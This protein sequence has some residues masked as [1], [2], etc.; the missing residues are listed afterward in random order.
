MLDTTTQR[1]TEQLPASQPA[2]RDFRQEVTNDIIRLL[3]QGVAPWQKPWQP[4]AVSLGMPMN[5]TTN[6]TY[7]GGNAVHLM[8]TGLRKGYA[9]PRWMTYRQASEGGWQVRQGEQGTQIEFWEVK[10]SADRTRPHRPD[11]RDEGRTSADGTDRD[12]TRL[13]H[14]VY[15]VFNAKQ[16]DGIPA[17]APKQHT[18]FEAIQAG[19]Q[20][21]Q[22]S[23]AQVVHDQA[24]RAFYN[25][26]QDR[27]HLP[28]K[29]AFRD[30]ASY[31]GTA[32]HELAHFSGHPS[33]LNR[34]TLTESYL[35]GDVNY[36][37]EELRAELASVFM[38]AERG[39]PH[40]PEQ[41]AAYV[42]SWIQALQQDKHEIFRAA[43]DASAITDYLLGLERQRSLA[44]EQPSAGPALTPGRIPSADRQLIQGPEHG[45]SGPPSQPQELADSLTAAQSI[46]AQALGNSAR[47]LTAETESGIYRG[48]ILG[49]TA[50][51][52]IQRQSAHTG[53]AHLK[54]S[55][56]R[57]PQVGDHVR[58]HYANSNGTVR[59]FRERAKTVELGR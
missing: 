52:V 15:T 53:I 50:C 20:I 26:A 14:R 13:I 38:A 5:P 34:P 32:L 8:A 3:E 2:A 9:D 19:E 12:K 11:D 22:S 36:A 1:A 39:I 4:G 30:A 24:D 27:I 54:D 55:L 35:F 43:H 56:D 57:Q 51:H 25:R 40:N 47:T 49:E 31:Y 41:H 16:M 33:R 37:K 23:G 17:Y 59:E 6:K 58:I 46:T 7:R 44:A 21:L 18:P 28:P 48:V 29:E 42:G 45:R 10:S